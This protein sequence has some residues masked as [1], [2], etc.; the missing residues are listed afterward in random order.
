MCIYNYVH[1]IYIYIYIHIY[2]TGPGKTGTR[3]HIIASISCSVCKYY[4]IPHG[5][6]HIL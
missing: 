4:P 1:I 2:V 5:F 6:L 3:V